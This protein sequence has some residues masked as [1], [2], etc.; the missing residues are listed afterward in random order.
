[1]ECLRYAFRVNSASEEIAVPQDPSQVDRKSALRRALLFAAK[2]TLA[3]AI[4]IYLVRTQRLGLSR[5]L[6]AFYSPGE[7]L[8]A[9]GILVALPFIV[10]YRWRLLLH[11]L[12]FD[13]HWADAVRLTFIGVFFD[14]FMPGGTSDVVRGYYFDRKFQPQRRIVAASSLV[15]DRFISIMALVLLACFALGLRVR[16]IRDDPALQT[17]ALI[18][19][20]AGLVFLLIFIFLC[21]GGNPGRDLLVKCAARFKAAGV[22]VRIYDAFRGY[23]RGAGL[24]LKALVL[25]LGCQLL[26]VLCFVL[27]AH[28]LGEVRLTLSDYIYL[29]PVGLI[30]AQIPISVGGIGVGH[31]AFYSLFRMAGS[32]LGAELFSLFI[33]IRF[34]AALPGLFF[35]FKAGRRPAM[36][37][38]TVAAQSGE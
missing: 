17:V 12:K 26:A 37:C 27:L 11:H 23:Q 21:A 30:V 5:L 38:L 32:N 35:F 28:A 19:G 10:S 7:L 16:S 31:V 15:V 13:V 14:T 20:A 6:P 29:V 36:P 34:I 2:A 4:V 9:L 1:M 25:S 18:A 8:A 24:L 3:V 22:A 33:V